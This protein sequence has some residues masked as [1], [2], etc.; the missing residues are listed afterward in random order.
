MKFYLNFTFDLNCSD[1]H[2][3]RRRIIYSPKLVKPQ[4]LGYSLRSLNSYLQTFFFPRDEYF[5]NSS[6]WQK[7]IVHLLYLFPFH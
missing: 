7:S 2:D 3:L 5:L 4:L 1:C 6:I